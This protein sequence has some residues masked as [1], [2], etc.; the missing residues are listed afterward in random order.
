MDVQQMK[1]VPR[2]CSRSSGAFKVE[3]F[4]RLRIGL[5]SV[6]KP[7]AGIESKILAADFSV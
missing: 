4:T 5:D 2:M 1:A 7:Q 3:V 6:A